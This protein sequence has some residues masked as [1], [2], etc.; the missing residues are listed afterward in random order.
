MS[1]RNFIAS[2]EVEAEA[3]LASI[4]AA[5]LAMEKT[6]EETQALKTSELV[7]RIT[8]ICIDLNNFRNEVSNS[9]MDEW[10]YEEP[11]SHRRFTAAIEKQMKQYLTAAAELDR[12][13]PVPG[14]V[15]DRN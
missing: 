1:W 3:Q 12:R 4:E 11:D 2:T 14:S 15:N 9:D 7:V 5:S 8:S 6:L 13:I 10:E